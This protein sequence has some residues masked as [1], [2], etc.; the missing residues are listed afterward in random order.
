MTDTNIQLGKIYM[1]ETEDGQT[2][3]LRVINETPT[4]YI[5]SSSANDL[6]EVFPKAKKEI[7]GIY[8]IKEWCK[9]HPEE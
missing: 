2:Q 1:V 8:E 9:A 5:F 4:H 7:L 6:V 3:T